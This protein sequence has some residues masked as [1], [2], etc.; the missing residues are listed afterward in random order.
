LS[1]K[2]GTKGPSEVVSR[3]LRDLGYKTSLSSRYENKFLRIL[4]IVFSI[5]F[6][7][8][9]IVQIDVF[10]G[11][12]FSIA[13]YSVFLA[14]L[15]GK[16]VVLNLHGG[17]LPEF[18]AKNEIVCRNVFNR[19][20]EIFTPSKY[21]QTYFTE[22][23][24]KIEYLPN[25][26][27]TS[28]FPFELTKKSCKILWVRA[29]TKIY[30]PD[31]AVDILELVKKEFPLATLTMIGP[32]LGQ[33]ASIEKYIEAKGLSSSVEILGVIDNNVLVNYFHHHS[34]YINTT[35][36]ESFG[37]AVL[38]A[39]SSGLP[40]VSTNVGEIPYLWKNQEDILIDDTNSSLGMA[41]LVNQLFRDEEKRIQLALN[42]KHR[43]EVF[44]WQEVKQLWVKNLDK[45]K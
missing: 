11:P 3:K 21:L 28:K 30:Q 45:L 4:D 18:Y 7:S 9:K 34:V 6:S 35:M 14:N 17:M 38:E 37:L 29:F 1:L 42:A 10:S 25:S 43:S 23:G 36:Y 22:L 13:R 32:D 24:F 27:D 16:K 26:I 8:D 39:A 41:N 20:I 2:K 40:V 31:L 19:V 33:R 15:L 44:S 5:V 12:S